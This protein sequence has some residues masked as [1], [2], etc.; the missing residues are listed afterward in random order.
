MRRRLELCTRDSGRIC[1]TVSS[2]TTQAELNVPNDPKRYDCAADGEQVDRA[3]EA[4]ED[5]QIGKWSDVSRSMAGTPSAVSG[6]A[7]C[8]RKERR[9]WQRRR[10]GG[11]RRWQ[12]ARGRDGEAARIWNDKGLVP[13]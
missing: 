4:G 3:T 10:R 1:G 7:L 9:G 6:A 2:E 8:G 5:V 12:R 13:I 11:R